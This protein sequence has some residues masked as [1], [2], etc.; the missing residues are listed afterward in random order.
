MDFN[1]NHFFLVGI[2]FVLLGL[3]FLSIKSAMLTPEFTK[4][5]AEQIEHPAATASNAAGT[6][7]GT[8]VALPPHRF[9]P[10]EWLPWCLLSIGSVLSLH[11]MALK[12]PG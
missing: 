9:V 1:R 4:F 5:L 10:P 2:V 6:L 7:L 11:A 12:K 8:E 3:Q